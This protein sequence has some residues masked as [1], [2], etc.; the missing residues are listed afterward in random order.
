VSYYINARSGRGNKIGK[1]LL[2]V[3]GYVVVFAL[4]FFISYKLVAST[5]TDTLQVQALKEEIT[6]LNTQ[7]AQKEER[8]SSLELQ[9]ENI[10]ESIAAREAQL[11]AENSPAE[12]EDDSPE[13][14]TE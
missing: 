7:L 6:A 2:Y 1:T 14:V 13:D 4:S 11:A 5:Q 8:I 12:G 10:R 9:V 3:L